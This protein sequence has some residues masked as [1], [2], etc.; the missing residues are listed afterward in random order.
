M[1]QILMTDDDSTKSGLLIAPVRGL[2][3]IPVENG[4]KPV[5]GVEQIERETV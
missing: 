5:A 4:Q 3:D 1:Q 2:P